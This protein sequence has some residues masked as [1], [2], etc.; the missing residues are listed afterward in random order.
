MCKVSC[1]LISDGLVKK[2]EELEKTAGMY[3][4]LSDHTRKLLKSFFE[5]AQ[6]HKGTNKKCFINL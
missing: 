5:L 6:S 2:L 1:G 3:K 4:G